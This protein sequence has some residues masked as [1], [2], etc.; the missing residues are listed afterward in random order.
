MQWVEKKVATHSRQKVKTY[1]T[2]TA[3]HA[4]MSERWSEEERQAE[5]THPLS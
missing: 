3:I 2:G 1:A 5:T 4:W